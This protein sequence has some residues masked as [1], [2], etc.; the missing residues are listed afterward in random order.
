M[1]DQYFCPLCS[2]HKNEPLTNVPLGVIDEGMI[3]KVDICRGCAV[4]LHNVR[5]IYEEEQKRWVEKKRKAQAVLGGKLN[6]G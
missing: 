3:I 4:I 1:S 2:K 5:R 6:G